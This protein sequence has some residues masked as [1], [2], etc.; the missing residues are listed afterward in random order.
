MPKYSLDPLEKV[1][2]NL[3]EGDRATLATFYP[4]AGWSVAA[5]TVIHKF[6]NTLRELESRQLQETLNIQ[7]KVDLPNMEEEAES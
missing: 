2:I 3:I 4:A 7:V 1:T 5:R 6:C